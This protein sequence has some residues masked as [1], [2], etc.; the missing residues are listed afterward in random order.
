MHWCGH[1]RAAK[2]WR[3]FLAAVLTSRVWVGAGAP[4]NTDSVHLVGCPTPNPRSLP[5]GNSSTL[6]GKAEF[7][8]QQS[9][10]LSQ[11]IMPAGT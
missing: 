8:P 1:R 4:F 5:V 7:T 3:M 6:G 9:T 2:T 10:T 11:V